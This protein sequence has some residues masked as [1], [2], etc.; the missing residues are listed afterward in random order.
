[1]THDPQSLIR[2]FDNSQEIK[3]SLRRSIEFERRV[4][5][6]AEA[7][8]ARYEEMLAELKEDGS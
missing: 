8:I 3:D 1:M 7:S 4:I 2:V 5:A 6:N